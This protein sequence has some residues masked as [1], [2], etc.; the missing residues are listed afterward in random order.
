MFTKIKNFLKENLL[1][2]LILIGIYLVLNIKLPYYIDTPGG[3]INL[4][5]K[6][7]I[8]NKI[9]GSFNMT[10]VS[11][12]KATVFGMI[13]KNF[14][15]DFDAHKLET[16]NTLVDHILLD[17]GN[18]NAIICAYNLAN[19]KVEIKDTTLK[20]IYIDEIA[21]TNLEVG[22]SIIKV[23]DTQISSLE[24]LYNIIQNSNYNDNLKIETNNGIKEAK[25][26]NYE[27]S[28]KIGISLSLKRNIEVEPTISFNFKENESGPSGGLMISL[29]IYSSLINEDLTKGKVISGTGTITDD[30][31]VGE[32][33]GVKYKLI[34]AVQNNA[35]VFFVPK[36]NYE[37]AI[38][39]KNERKYNIDIV[40]V[41]HIN[42]AINYLK[43][44]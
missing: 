32:I 9:E 18:D 7:N 22:E 27:N 26:I 12:F 37:E 25:I 21:K 38:K 30:G 29:Y 39:I 10:Y 16:D 5:E 17:E 6:V 14:Y 4:N 40:K 20:I 23:N 34:G 41:T 8:E 1:S 2:I 24:D 44:M 28:K 31:V 11:Q 19:K 35:D 13:M 15:K 3:L 36:E 33:G 43:N 42:D